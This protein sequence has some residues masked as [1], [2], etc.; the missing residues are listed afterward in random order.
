MTP[1]EARDIDA[2]ARDRNR[3]DGVGC[4]L[5]AV[6]LSLASWAA[7]ALILAAFFGVL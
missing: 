2:L 1:D 6:M 5:A 7:L 4:S 3:S